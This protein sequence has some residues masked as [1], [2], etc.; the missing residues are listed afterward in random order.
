MAHTMRRDL[1]ARGEYERV[2]QGPG[3][4][5]WRGQTRPRVFTFVWVRDDRT[6]S[7]SPNHRSAN[8]FCA[9]DRF[10]AYHP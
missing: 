4:C 1:F 8:T 2:C 10:T 7:T 5:A 3:Q 9:F 6:Q